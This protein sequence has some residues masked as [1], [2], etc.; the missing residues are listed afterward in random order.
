M[1]TP[2]NL[3]DLGQLRSHAFFIETDL[4]IYSRRDVSDPPGSGIIVT[5]RAVA[6]PFHLSTEEWLDV[7]HLLKQAIGNL[8]ETW[9]PDGYTIGWNCGYS[10]GQRVHQAHLH[11]IPRFKDEPRSGLGLRAWVMESNQR[12][13]P[14]AQGTAQLE[15]WPSDR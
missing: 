14:T 8:N 1:T 13:D 15:V 11:V 12:I 2:N 6:F 7:H 5:K 4:S 3:F 9:H 10:A